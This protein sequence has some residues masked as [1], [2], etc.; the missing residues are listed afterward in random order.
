MKLFLDK[1]LLSLTSMGEKNI[2]VLRKCILLPYK[3]KLILPDE[4]VYT[5][6]RFLT[7]K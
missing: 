5:A 4:S 1:L 2:C 6:C 3:Q 7:Y